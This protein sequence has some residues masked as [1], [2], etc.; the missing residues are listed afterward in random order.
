MVHVNGPT[1]APEE[2]NYGIDVAG[3]DPASL[4]DALR[5]VVDGRDDGPD[6]HD[7]LDDRLCDGRAERR[8][9]HAAAF[10]RRWGRARGLRRRQ[11]LLRAGMARESDAGGSRRG[12][13]ACGRD[14]A[15]ALGGVV[16]RSPRRRAARRDSRCSSCA[17]RSRRA[18]CRGSTRACSKRRCDTRRR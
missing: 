8:V 2:L 5:A 11:A 13:S 7:D 16:S 10:E 18:T 15:L 17:T 1:I 3:L 12:L 9:E 4:G 14:A 6:A